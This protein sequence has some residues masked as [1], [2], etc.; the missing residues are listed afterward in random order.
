MSAPVL[1]LMP[2]LGSSPCRVSGLIHLAAARPLQSQRRHVGIEQAC[3]TSVCLS[4]CVQRASLKA[5]TPGGRTLSLQRF[6]W[7]LR[8]RTPPPRQAVVPFHKSLPL[9]LGVGRD[10]TP[11]GQACTASSGQ[12]FRKRSNTPCS[13]KSS[14][15]AASERMQKPKP[16]RTRRTTPSST[17]PPA[18]AGRTNRASTKSRGSRCEAAPARWRPL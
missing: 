14:S 7:P 10:G 15:S 16:R 9:A 13:T 17:L 2:P 4:V 12:T 1:A 5:P 3:S 8:V 11:S 6:P 18:R